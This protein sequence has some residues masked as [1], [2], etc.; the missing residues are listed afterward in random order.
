[1]WLAS[2]LCLREVDRALW[3]I[4]RGRAWPADLHP[5]NRPAR[6]VAGW[7]YRPAR[8]GL[9]VADCTWSYV[10]E[11]GGVQIFK[12]TSGGEMRMSPAEENDGQRSPE[13]RRGR[14][15]GWS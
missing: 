6:A 15:M 7:R 5:A 8:T 9:V 11:L 4:C 13:P 3:R 14:R 1:M 2:D 12:P 10:P